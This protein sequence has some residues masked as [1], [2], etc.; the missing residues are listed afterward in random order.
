MRSISIAR[1]IS[2]FVILVSLILAGQAVA[3]SDVSIAL[4][5]STGQV[6]QD[7][8]FTVAVQVQSGGGSVDGAEVHLRFDPA[9]LQVAGVLADASLPVTILPPAFDNQAGTIDYA[10]GALR[11][12]PERDFALLVI[13]FAAVVPDAET[14]IRFA[15]RAFPTLTDITFDGA[16]VLGRLTEATVRIGAAAQVVEAVTAAPTIEVVPTAEAEAAVVR[17][18]GATGSID[19]QFATNTG[20]QIVFAAPPAS[21]VLVTLV[22]DGQCLVTPALFVDAST[23]LSQAVIVTAVDDADPEAEQHACVITHTVVSEDETFDGFALENVIVPVIDNDAVGAASVETVTTTVEAVVL[24]TAAE[25]PPLE[26][27]MLVVFTEVPAESATEDPSRALETPI[28][29]A[30]EPAQSPETDAVTPEEPA[31]PESET[32]EQPLLPE[33]TATP[34][35]PVTPPVVIDAADIL[36][37]EATG[38]WASGGADW[39]TTSSGTLTWLQPIDLPAPISMQLRFAALG[40]GD[41]VR[42]VEVS[43]DLLTWYP[44]MQSGSLSESW[45]EVTV[46]LSAFAGQVIWLRWSS[47]VDAQ[48]EA[49]WTISGAVIDIVPP[50]PEPTAEP[51]LEPVIPAATEAPVAEPTAAPVVEPTPDAIPTAEPTPEAES[52]ASA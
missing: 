36:A 2:I 30:E 29:A 46:D 45:S 37:W 6:A 25:L 47:I 15:E 42:A 43:T 34:R 18:E 50:T 39:S 1:V 40:S 26:G 48:T 22:S 44:L 27:D 11:N 10:A 7:E 51:T 17:I 31:A 49:T 38:G 4:V 24:Q 5:P 20:Y 16:S 28:P 14:T 19:E 12:F 41:A 3:Q 32:V 33:P 21:S 23:P 35:E 9:V 8:L 13:T 52:T